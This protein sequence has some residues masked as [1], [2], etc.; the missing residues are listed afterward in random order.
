MGYGVFLFDRIQQVFI[1]AST[2]GTTRKEGWYFAGCDGVGELSGESDLPFSLPQIGGNASKPFAFLRNAFAC[3]DGV[4]FEVNVDELRQFIVEDELSLS[5]AVQDGVRADGSI[6]DAS[7]VA[8]L[9]P[10]VSSIFVKIQRY[11]RFP[12]VP[13]PRPFGPIKTLS[14]QREVFRGGLLCC[15]VFRQCS[16]N[17][18]RERLLSRNARISQDN[19]G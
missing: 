7:F 19:H 17:S 1:Y 13:L 5:V 15:F 9:V 3:S 6:L 2:C 12:P 11:P 10:R 16:G 18:W 14:Q 4:L 8:S